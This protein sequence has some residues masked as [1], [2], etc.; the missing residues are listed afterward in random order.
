[1]D[2]RSAGLAANALSFIVFILIAR[3]YAV[4][5]LRATTRDRA[6]TALLWV[7][8]FRYVALEL[9][10]AQR[11]GL[12]IPDDLRDQIAYGDVVGALLALLCIVLLRYRVRAAVP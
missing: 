3:W 10:S 7:N 11:A 6:L 12:A 5:W 2:T 1:M 4:P 9:F 8:A